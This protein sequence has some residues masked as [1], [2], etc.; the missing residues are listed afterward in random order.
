MHTGGFF[1]PGG[2]C[3]NLSQPV[4]STRKCSEAYLRRLQQLDNDGGRVW[5]EAWYDAWYNGFVC[6]RVH[7]LT[8]KIVELEDAGKEGG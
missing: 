5:R 8:A 1:Q 6:A 7:R 2:I 4:F 3:L